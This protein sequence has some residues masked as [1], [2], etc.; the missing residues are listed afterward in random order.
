MI[1]E[2][3]PQARQELV[4]AVQW[5]LAEGG[6]AV[7]EQFG[8]A[9][10]RALQLLSFMP[11][12]GTAYRGSPDHF[13]HLVACMRPRPAAEAYLRLRTLPG[14]QAQVDWGHF[15]HLAVGRAR[16]PLMAFVMVLSYSRRIFLR[17]F[18]D[19]VPATH[20]AYSEGQW[21]D[22]FIAHFGMS[23]YASSQQDA[24]TAGLHWLAV[25]REACRIAAAE[26]EIRERTRSG[27]APATGL[28]EDDAASAAAVLPTG[29]EN[30]GAPACNQT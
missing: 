24:L 7:A 30:R 2:F 19:V 5:Y 22:I 11:Q 16:R 3:R 4:D 10:E 15:G 20:Y 26:L 18:L 23:D 28:A 13:R 12:I 27:R 14:E 25:A 8:W 29:G 1:V 17:F 9:V 21:L 6:A